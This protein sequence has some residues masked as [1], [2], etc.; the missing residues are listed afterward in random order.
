MSNLDRRAQHLTIEGIREKIEEYKQE[1]QDAA[2][3]LDFEQA[4]HFRDLMRQ[5]QDLELVLDFR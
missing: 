1:M 2:K 5:Y 4:A 3:K